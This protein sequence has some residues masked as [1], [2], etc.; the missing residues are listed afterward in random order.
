[1]G[2]L[3]KP[4]F[5]RQIGYTNTFWTYCCPMSL[6]ST[7]LLFH[8]QSNNNIQVNAQQLAVLGRRPR[9]MMDSQTH[10]VN[11]GQLGAIFKCTRTQHTLC[12]NYWP[13][14]K[15]QTRVPGKSCRLFVVS[16][17]YGEV[18]YRQRWCYLGRHNFH[19]SHYRAPQ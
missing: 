18:A 7:N 16:G 13:D 15:N 12:W 6:C 14:L 1:M 10:S 17:M 5:A 9:P 2:I 11:A 4:W 8:F 19:Q 3:V